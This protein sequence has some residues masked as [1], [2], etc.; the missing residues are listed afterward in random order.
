VN[1]KVSHAAEELASELV[2]NFGRAVERWTQ[3]ME[4]SSD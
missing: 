1:A 3:L 2:A 4:A